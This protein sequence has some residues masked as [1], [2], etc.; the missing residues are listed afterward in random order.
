MTPRPGPPYEWDENK[1]QLNFQRRGFGFG[2][3]HNFDWNTAVSW[4]DLR[5]LEE[6][7]RVSIGLIEGRLYVTVWTWR[8]GFTRIIS[9][10]KANRREAIIY[11]QEKS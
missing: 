1:N 9:L 8:E 6:D 5:I 4:Q 7:R 11:A 10:R 2:L 3:I